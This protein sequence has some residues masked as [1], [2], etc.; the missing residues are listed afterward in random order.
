M[1]GVS[2]DAL[3]ANPILLGPNTDPVVI[4]WVGMAIWVS[5]NSTLCAFGAGIVAGALCGRSSMTAVVWLSL[6]WAIASP[7]YVLS[8]MPDLWPS[9][10]LAT[11]PVSMVSGTIAG[12]CVGVLLRARLRTRQARRVT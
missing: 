10:Y 3:T 8:S 2:A 9:W 4:R 11:F 1:L 5:A 7:I 6:L 12:G